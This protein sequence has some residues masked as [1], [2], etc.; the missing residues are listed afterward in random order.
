KVLFELWEKPAVPLEI[1]VI[2]LVA[3]PCSWNPNGERALF[4]CRHGVSEFIR[5]IGA[6]H[7]R[8][9]IGVPCGGLGRRLLRPRAGRGSY[10]S[11]V[12]V[13]LTHRC[14]SG[15]GEKCQRENRA[16]AHNHPL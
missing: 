15:G 4:K 11:H 14:S 12:R 2:V 6:W 8:R 16:K 13:V 9:R 1:L 5:S 7:R 10:S 3:Q